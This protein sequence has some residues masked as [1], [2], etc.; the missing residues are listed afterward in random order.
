MNGTPPFSEHFDDIVLFLSWRNEEFEFGYGKVK[1][2][3]RTECNAHGKEWKES[4]SN[5]TWDVLLKMVWRR[6][7]HL[8]L[9]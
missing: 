6:R 9:N 2:N 4:F 1:L 5:Q 8:L 7:E 3:G